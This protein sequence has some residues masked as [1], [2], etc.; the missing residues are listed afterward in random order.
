VIRVKV[1]PA[2]NANV[3]QVL[4]PLLTGREAAQFANRL[5]IAAPS[6][7]RWISTAE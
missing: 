3:M 6:R 7:V 1:H 5:V 4:V 2:S